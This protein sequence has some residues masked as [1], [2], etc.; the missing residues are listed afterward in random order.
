MGLPMNHIVNRESVGMKTFSSQSYNIA[1]EMEDVCSHLKQMLYDAN[2]YMQDAS[3]QAAIAII[4]ELVEESTVAVG[5]I[6]ALADRIQKSAE[7]LEE[8]NTLL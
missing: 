3:G 4:E 6:R 1:N 8:S 7:L 5:V 2:D